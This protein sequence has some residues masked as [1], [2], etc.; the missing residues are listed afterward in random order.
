[1]SILEF[2]LTL[3]FSYL[4]GSYFGIELLVFHNLDTISGGFKFEAGIPWIPIILA[5]FI[6]YLGWKIGFKKFPDENLGN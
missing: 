4:I 3:V 2:F 5:L 1:M 6:T